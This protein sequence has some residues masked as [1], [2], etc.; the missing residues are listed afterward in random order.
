MRFFAWEWSVALEGKNGI[1][2]SFRCPITP[3]SGA[4]PPHLAVEAKTAHR[5]AQLVRRCVLCHWANGSGGLPRQDSSPLAHSW[6]AAGRE[7]RD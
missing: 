2:A 4:P 7:G 1:R 6:C 5:S 3:I